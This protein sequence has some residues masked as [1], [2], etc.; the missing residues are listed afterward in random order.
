MGTLGQSAKDYD[1]QITQD[2]DLISQR[3]RAE[4]ATRA[5]SEF[6]ASMSHEIRTPM[7]GVI[8]AAGLLMGTQLTSEQREYAEMIRGSG[9]LLLQLINDI[10]DL[11]RIEAG[12][13]TIESAPFALKQ[14]LGEVQDLLAARVA[15]RPVRLMMD[16]PQALPTHFFGDAGRIRQIVLNL[17]GNAVKF[18]T[19]GVVSIVVESESVID[20]IARIRISVADT[21]PGIAAE[22]V[23]L[24]FQRFSQLQARHAR[25]GTGLGLAISKQLVEAMGGEIGVMSREGEGSTFWFAL[26]LP[27]VQELPSGNTGETDLLALKAVFE[28]KPVRVLVAEDN[29]VNQR[30]AVRMLEKLGVLADVAANGQE[31][32]QMSTKWPYDLILMDCLMPEMDGYQATRAIRGWEGDSRRLPII[33]M[34]ADAFAECRDRCLGAGMNGF[35]AKPVKL[36]DLA[37]I[38]A[39]HVAAC[40]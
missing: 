31:A 9:E 40:E 27:V 22:Q 33:A 35:L 39:K 16:Y 26:P 29:V 30:V 24:L 8:G 15:D 37:S 36:T 28:G 3:A 10:L 6:L 1:C 38:L 5:K 4:E 34:T 13:M 7:N 11:S 20:G 12:R 25:I 21:G 19:K 17:A 23:P 18:T 32:V 14:A 2:I